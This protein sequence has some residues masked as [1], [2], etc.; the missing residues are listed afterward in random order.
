V[1]PPWAQLARQRVLRAR[2]HLSQR[3]SRQ[4]RVLLRTV[5]GVVERLLLDRLQTV[6][7]LN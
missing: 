1:V 3:E 4:L 5:L 2:D 7:V 6:A